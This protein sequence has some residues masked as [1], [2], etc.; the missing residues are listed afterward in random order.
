MSLPPDKDTDEVEFLG[1]V[2]M[3]DEPPRESFG[4]EPMD[5]P[6]QFLPVA[7]RPKWQVLTAALM[8]AAMVVLVVALV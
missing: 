2:D 1:D 7:R 8:V 3:F 6:W 5:A 4:L